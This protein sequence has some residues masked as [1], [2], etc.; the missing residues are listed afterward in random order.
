MSDQHEDMT[1]EEIVDFIDGNRWTFAKTMPW[2]PHEYTLKA[3]VSDPHM[4][5]RFVMHIRRNGYDKSF[6]KRAFTYFDVGIWQYW[7][8]GS[9]LDET[10]LINRAKRK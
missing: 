8:M 2:H 3:N 4:F 10:I 7:T 9:P 5:E 6:G 1:I